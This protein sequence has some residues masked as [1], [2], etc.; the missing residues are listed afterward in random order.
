M[1]RPAPPPHRVRSSGFAIL[2][3]AVKFEEQQ[4][5]HYE[6]SVYYPVRIGFFF[7]KTDDLVLSK[8]GFGAN[9]TVWFYRNLRWANLGFQAHTDNKYGRQHNYVALKFRITSPVVNREVEVFKHI[10]AT[11]STSYSI[12]F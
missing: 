9:S 12:E 11:Q 5:P 6:K 8:L 4:I 3:K 1:R 2:D 10:V 7:L